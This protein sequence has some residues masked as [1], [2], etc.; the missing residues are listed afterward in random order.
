MV[1][2]HRTNKKS[3]SHKRL[4]NHSASLIASNNYGMDTAVSSSPQ[5]LSK[6]SQSSQHRSD[7]LPQISS[8]KAKNRG[9]KLKLGDLSHNE[10]KKQI[11]SMLKFDRYIRN[12]RVDIEGNPDGIEPDRRIIHSSLADVNGIGRC[13]LEISQ[14]PSRFY[15][16]LWRTRRVPNDYAFCKVPHKMA[17]KLLREDDNQI[18]HFVGRLYFKNG[19]LRLLGFNY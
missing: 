11:K 4:Q 2:K 14:S 9:I 16:I 10:A 19:S 17:E 13:W 3:P 12:S 1:H 15:V 5:R 6:V 8:S 7:S 18:G